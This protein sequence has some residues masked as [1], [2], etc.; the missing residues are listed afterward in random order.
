[1]VSLNK[2]EIYCKVTVYYNKT[3]NNEHYFYSLK[4]A[5]KYVLEI[6]DIFNVPSI[7]ETLEIVDKNIIL[8]NAT[9]PFKLVINR[10]PVG[11]WAHSEVLYN[12]KEIKKR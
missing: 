1:M 10:I 11:P 12:I 9:P 6:I 4:D 7:W 3:K 5:L 2:K 8:T